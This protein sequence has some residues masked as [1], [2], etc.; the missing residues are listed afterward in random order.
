LQTSVVA[1]ARQQIH[2]QKALVRLHLHFD[3]VGNLNR[4]LNFSEI[5]TLTFPDMMVRIRH[6]LP[7]PLRA[8]CGTPRCGQRAVTRRDSPEVSAHTVALRQEMALEV[9][10]IDSLD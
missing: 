5:Q 8:N 10:E 1:L 4:A 2:L 3:Q 9:T 7:H 6:E